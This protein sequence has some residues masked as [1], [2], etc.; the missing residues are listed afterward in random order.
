MKMADF[1]DVA[2]CGLLGTDRRFRG[3]Y[4]LRS[5]DPDNTRN[6][7][8][9]NVSQHVPEHMAQHNLRQPCSE[10]TFVVYLMPLYKQQFI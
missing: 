9:L 10:F 4:C 3:A 7:H 8:L 1:W 2:P 5:F 6:K